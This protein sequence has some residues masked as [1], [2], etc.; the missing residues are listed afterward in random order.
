MSVYPKQINSII[1][2]QPSA[3]LSRSC[4]RK[5]NDTSFLPN[6]NVI[7]IRSLGILDYCIHWIIS[8]YKKALFIFKF[9][10][11]SDLFIY[12]FVCLFIY[13]FIILCAAIS[14]C[15]TSFFFF[16]FFFFWIKIT[17]NVWHNRLEP[18][19]GDQLGE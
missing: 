11:Q 18:H 19:H 7:Y 17:C 1:S 9:L 6:L 10:I 4:P 16:F 15:L 3:Y 2:S 5:C 8:L 14:L 12:L 13:L